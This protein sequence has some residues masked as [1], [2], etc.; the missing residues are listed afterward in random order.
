MTAIRMGVP[1]LRDAVT[2]PG[3]PAVGWPNQRTSSRCL[4]GHGGVRAGRDRFGWYSLQQMP[5]LD[6]P[7]RDRR[8]V[9]AR[10]RVSGHQSVSMP[11]APSAAGA[12]MVVGLARGCRFLLPPVGRRTTWQYPQQTVSSPTATPSGLPLHEVRWG[13]SGTPRTRYLGERSWSER[14]CFRPGWLARSVAQLGHPF[15]VRPEPWR[16][17][18][19]PAWSPCSTWSPTTMGSSSSPNSSRP[20][21]SRIWS[22]PRDRYHRCKWPRSAPRWRVCWRSLIAPGSS[23]ATSSRPM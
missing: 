19:I 13:Q 12:A 1:C 22:G 8:S 11:L 2:E 21:A 5:W 9:T 18:P 6:R 4:A 20:P 7:R 17:S 23:T 3:Y 16:G 10:R 15:L 14:L